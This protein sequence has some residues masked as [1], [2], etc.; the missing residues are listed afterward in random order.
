MR[1]DRIRKRYKLEWTKNYVFGDLCFWYLEKHSRQIHK[2]E[3]I[4]FLMQHESLSTYGVP[5][6]V[7]KTYIFDDGIYH[8]YLSDMLR[9]EEPDA[10]Y[11][12]KHIAEKL[13]QYNYNKMIKKYEK[14][15]EKQLNDEIKRLIETNSLN[16]EYFIFEKY[17]NH[18]EMKRIRMFSHPFLFFMMGIFTLISFAIV[19]FFVVDL[20]S[21]IGITIRE[22]NLEETQ[23]AL[24]F[25]SISIFFAIFYRKRAIKKPTK[26]E[27]ENSF[28]LTTLCN[29]TNNNDKGLLYNDE[30]T[31]STQV[32]P[33]ETTQIQTNL[34]IQNIEKRIFSDVCEMIRECAKKYPGVQYAVTLERSKV[35]E[36]ESEKL[37]Q[38]YRSTIYVYLARNHIILE[39]KEDE[40][41][42]PGSSSEILKIVRTKISINSRYKEE[43][44]EGIEWYS[45]VY[46]GDKET[47]YENKEESD[48]FVEEAYLIE[49]IDE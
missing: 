23:Q 37:I 44:C 45:Q 2:L 12:E 15:T 22:Y 34:D 8:R 48:R 40:G 49:W 36:L 17:L 39:R 33:I 18:K 21:F 13:K 1:I 14:Y 24:L 19:L 4:L 46:L 30:I 32:I 28:P 38:N 41:E 5:L 11:D 42:W 7:Y 16:K 29:E 3:K 20:L 25:G 47:H 26:Y 27:S 43:I 9:I 35:L 6:L 10:I 31:I